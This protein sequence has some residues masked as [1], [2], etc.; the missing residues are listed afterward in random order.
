MTR[1]SDVIMLPVVSKQFCSALQSEFL[2]RKRPCAVNGG[3]F[4]VTD[5]AGGNE[6]FRV[7]GCGPLVKHQ[8][9]LKD[10]EGKPILTLKRKVGVVE[11]FSFH[12]QWKGFVRDEI[13]DGQEKPIFKVTASSLSCSENHPIRV[14]L[15]NPSNHKKRPEYEIV[16]SFT[17]RACGIYDDSNSIV[18][19]VK[20]NNSITNV[21]GIMKD[22]YSVVVQPGVDQAFVFGLVAV[23]DKITGDDS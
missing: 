16:G 17:E 22:I 5:R 10:G 21:M 19:E 20:V 6:V 7:E 12:K 18:A 8:A 23:L 1:N 2:V 3:G 13:N 11:V 15:T 9:V 14:S 4:V